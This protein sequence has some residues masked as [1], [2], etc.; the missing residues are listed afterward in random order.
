MARPG[1]EA[2]DTSEHL[3]LA[4]VARDT[5]RYFERTVS[6]LDH[7]LP[8]DNLQTLPAYS[9]AHRTSPTNI[10]LYLLSTACARTF[11]WIGTMDMLERLEATLA[12]LQRLERVRGHFLNWYDT[13]TARPL[14]PQYVSTVDSGNLSGHLLTVAQACLQYS[15]SPWNE[16]E[17]AQALDRARARLMPLLERRRSLS[18][19]EREALRCLLQDHQATKRSL[20]RDRQARL[21][22]HTQVVARLQACA[23]ALEALAWQ[24][25]FA[26]LY[27]PSR[28]LLHI[29]FRVAEQQL[30]AGYY[31]LLA[32]EARLTSFLAIAKGDV[33]VQHW[34]A[35]ARMFYALGA[36]V[37]LRSWSGSMFEYLMPSLVLEEPVGSVLRAKSP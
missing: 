6:A 4:G 24:P 11:G 1:S 29:G 23:S 30:D 10:G 22:Q 5:W 8:P 13:Q 16:N 3:Y 19:G 27:N 34:S 33:P 31:D 25:D 32:S 37:G 17:A 9:L 21:A 35:L 18:H 15:Q 36:R 26:F 20:R 14:L 12:T 28:K 7:H 2:L